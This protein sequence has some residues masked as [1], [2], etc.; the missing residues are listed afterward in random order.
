MKHIL[1][2]SLLFSAT[3]Y[4]LA[5]VQ[6]TDPWIRGTVPLQEATGA[7][8]QLQ[9][10]KDTRLTDAASPV[11]RVEIHEMSH[12]GD[13][14]RMRQ[15][16][17]LDLPAGKTVALKPG[18]YHLMFMGLK[19]PLKEGESVP[20]TLTFKDGSGKQETVELSVPVRAL[21]A[22]THKPKHHH[23]GH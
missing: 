17:G 16:E 22:S 9:S 23:A 6:V 18:S 7:F 8:M 11:A 21:T 1:I 15:I 13:V 5:Q 3:P 2:A 14:M 12:Q 10:P 4:A 19:A 20:L